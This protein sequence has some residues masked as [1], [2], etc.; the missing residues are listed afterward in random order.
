ME[1]TRIQNAVRLGFTSLQTEN[2]ITQLETQGSIPSWITGSLIFLGPAQFEAGKHTVNHWL[3]GLA[4]LHAFSFNNSHV[5]YTNTFL[6]SNSY[7]TVQKKKNILYPGFAQDPQSSFYQ[8]FL[9]VFTPS[10]SL[11]ESKNATFNI[12]Q[13]GDSY[14]ALAPQVLPVKF[15]PDTLQ[16]LGNLDYAHNITY[17]AGYE[18]PY[19]QYDTH[20]K[21]LISY[22]VTFGDPNI[23]HVYAL[24][25]NSTERTIIAEFT[26]PTLYYTQNLNLTHHHIIITLCPLVSNS[27]HIML[28]NKPFIQNFQWKPELGT[29]FIVIERSTGKLLK[30]YI[31]TPFFTFH[32]VNA[33]EHENALILDMIS[34]ADNTFI[35]YF[36]FDNLQNPKNSFNSGFLT[37][38]TLPLD[39]RSVWSE[40]ISG[41][42][43]DLPAINSQI[44]TQDYQYV[45]GAEFNPHVK[46]R[47]YNFLMKINVKTHISQRWFKPY[48]YPSKPI[49]IPDPSHISEDNGILIS[50]VLDTQKKKS[51]LLFLDAKHFTQ[52]AIAQLPNHIPFGLQGI[53]K[54]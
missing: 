35:D 13:I 51:F 48:C 39:N 8:R 11:Q 25:D 24:R 19:P 10:S 23:Y 21:E 53:Y 38:Y 1:E 37:R 6:K 30:K 26:T 47:N 46:K 40:I 43:L 15:D 32:Q 54:K 5:T 4:M 31:S 49:F 50:V 27:A 41:E 7:Y 9:A 2:H 28:K 18:N 45:Y 17:N 20:K 44:F 29:T 3:D 33:F 14:V 34:Y 52:I 36:Y 16:T 22:S 42:Q 12:A